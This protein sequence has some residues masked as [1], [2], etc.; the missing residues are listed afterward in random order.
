MTIKIVPSRE[1]AV[2]EFFLTTMFYTNIT[3]NYDAICDMACDAKA[4]TAPF[5]W[6]RNAMH[7][8]YADI[9][10]ISFSS[11]TGQLKNKRLGVSM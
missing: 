2:G 3:I 6:H 8:A 4:P 10:K 11:S 9:K 5:I 7:F 1:I